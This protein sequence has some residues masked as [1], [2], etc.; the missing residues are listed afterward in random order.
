MVL[1]E[2]FSPPLGFGDMPLSRKCAAHTRCTARG[3]RVPPWN[4]RDQ[5][6]GAQPFAGTGR[7]GGRDHPYRGTRAPE[8]VARQ[9]P[10]PWWNQGLEEGFFAMT[11][12]PVVLRTTTTRRPDPTSPRPGF[13]VY[14]GYRGLV[15]R[16][17]RRKSL[18]H[19]VE[20]RR[21]EPDLCIANAA[22]VQLVPP[23]SKPLFYEMRPPFARGRPHARRDFWP[24]VRPRHGVIMPLDAG[25]D[26]HSNGTSSSTAIK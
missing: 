11:G 25:H 16:Y 21:V 15:R 1:V 24:Y 26:T 20:R 6:R 9:K 10:V 7:A 4:R 19:K 5:R 14:S 22:L 13:R 8:R 3:N 18:R 12:P 2:P 23:Q 17:C